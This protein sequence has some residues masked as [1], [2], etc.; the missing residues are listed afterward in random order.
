VNGRVAV[1][2]ELFVC[3][4][5]LDD[6]FGKFNEQFNERFFIILMKS[7]NTLRVELKNLFELGDSGGG[8]GGRHDGGMSERSSYFAHTRIEWFGEGLVRELDSMVEASDV[9]SFIKGVLE[10]VEGSCLDVI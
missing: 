9:V 8:F 10:F 7:G 4:K 6:I 5:R 1:W 3:D 2:V